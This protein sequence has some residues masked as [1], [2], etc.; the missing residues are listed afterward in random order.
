MYDNGM[1]KAIVFDYFDVLRPDG[2]NA[3]L[4]NHDLQNEG[5][6]FEVIQ[7]HDMGGLSEVDMFS[8]LGKHTGQN[9]SAVEAEMEANI[10]PDWDML[11]YTQ[12]LR[13][14][15][16]I[17]LLSNSAAEYLRNE[18]R[19]NDLER[20]FDEIVISA[21]V[22]MAKPE[23][24]IFRLITDKLG[25]TLDECAF[26]DDN[27]KHVKAANSLGVTGILFEGKLKLQQSIGKLQ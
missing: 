16:K 14:D 23:D 26:V 1:I 12:S 5:Q 15:Y 22:G 2:F 6:I 11:D 4:R 20:Y 3:W 24:S 8:A 17:G 9:A 10:T 21:E 19:Q 7:Q 13:D 25:V 27:P 18:L